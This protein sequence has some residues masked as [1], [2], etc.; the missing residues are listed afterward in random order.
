MR[1]PEEQRSELSQELKLIEKKLGTAGG[2]ELA[3]LLERFWEIGDAIEEL[4]PMPTEP[5]FG[6]TGEASK[7]MARGRLP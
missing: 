1:T 2:E 6:T 3:R 5:G 4:Q 7:R